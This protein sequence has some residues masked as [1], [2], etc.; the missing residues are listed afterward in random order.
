MNRG[1]CKVSRFY[2][3]FMYMS[4]MFKDFR[5]SSETA[6]FYILPFQVLW[7]SQTLTKVSALSDFQW[8]Q[9]QLCLIKEYLS[10]E[11]SLCFAKF[12]LAVRW[13]CRKTVLSHTCTKNVRGRNKIFFWGE[14]SSYCFQI[15]LNFIFM[16]S[17]TNKDR[18]LPFLLLQ[19]LEKGQLISF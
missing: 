10:F 12:F 4:S 3:L 13:S 15:A 18:V 5:W 6:F 9:L 14:Q 1:V 11:Y 2:L 7:L 17:A 16:G 19:H 8:F